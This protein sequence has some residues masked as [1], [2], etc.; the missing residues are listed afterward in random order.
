VNKAADHA[1]ELQGVIK[2]YGEFTALHKTD[3]TIEEGA[4]L[5]LLGP[6][7]CG[8]TTTLRMIAGLTAI[9]DGEINIMG[10]RVNDVPIHKRNLGIV[11]QNYALFPHKTVF[12]NVAFGLKYRNVGKD[13]ARQRVDQ[14]LELVQ[15]PHTADRMP[16]QLSGG[17]QQRVALARAL[18]M[19]PKLLLLDEP[20][21]GLDLLTKQAVLEEIARLKAELGFG[22]I[23]VTHDP[24]EVRDLCNSLAVLK[25][26]RI[27]EHGSLEELRTSAQSALGKAFV[28]A[29]Q[30]TT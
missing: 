24:A 10:N 28:Q 14:A 26:G 29:M 17:Q 22:I 9:S 7:G 18:A 15:L 20:L 5:T 1:V 12:D 8:K 25:G 19:H 3:L 13:E 16:S 11:F 21:G 4:F 2:R 30:G 27:A 23:L 6:S